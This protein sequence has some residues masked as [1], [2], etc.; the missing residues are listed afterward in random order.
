MKPIPETLDQI[1]NNH[2]GSY[3]NSDA[4]SD[5]QMLSERTRQS[6]SLLNR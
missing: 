5:A 2:D 1:T 3:N 6:M 4:R